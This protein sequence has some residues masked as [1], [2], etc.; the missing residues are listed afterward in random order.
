MPRGY[1]VSEISYMALNNG[2]NGLAGRAKHYM[3]M[4]LAGEMVENDS[5]LHKR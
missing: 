1:D 2:S 5:G 4:I 3:Q